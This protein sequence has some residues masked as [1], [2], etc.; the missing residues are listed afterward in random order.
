[1]HPRGS[2]LGPNLVRLPGSMAGAVALTFDDG[3]DP[4]VTP[5]VLDLLDRHG[6]NA[7]F[8]VIGRKA[9]RHGALLREMLRRGHTVE[10]HSHH[11]RWSFA[12]RGPW[13]LRREVVLAQRAIAEATGVAPRF[14]RAPMG[15]RSPLLDPV[16]A[17]EG[18][19]LVVLDP[20]WLRRAPGRDPGGCW[21]G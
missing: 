18:L 14:F 2:Q 21:S 10:N 19:Q 5:R 11:H 20:A 9:A 13:A 16:L 7:S 6:A 15:L 4:E 8:F 1:M 17:M 3:P 12:C